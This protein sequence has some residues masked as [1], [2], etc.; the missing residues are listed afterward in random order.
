MIY[1]IL[2]FVILPA[3]IAAFFASVIP[4]KHKDKERFNGAADTFRTKVITA[5]EGIYPITRTWWDESLFPKFPQSVPKIETAA[6]EFSHFI[7]CKTD[8]DIA[9]KKYHDYCQRSTYKKCAPRIEYPNTPKLPNS[10]IDHIEEFKNI[11]EHILSF[12]KK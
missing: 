7:K 1:Q 2:G 10:D 3:L 5:L 9:V 6:A 12:A 4:R 11:V 8:L